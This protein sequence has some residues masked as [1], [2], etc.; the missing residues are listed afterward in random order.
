MRGVNVQE[1]VE[2]R[3]SIELPGGKI[4]RPD[5]VVQ[6]SDVGF[7]GIIETKG[8]S[9]RFGDTRSMRQ[10]EDNLRISQATGLPLYY[11]VYG[12]I[13]PWWQEQLRVNN[14]QAL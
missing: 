1:E 7:K 5:F 10:F 2:S 13:D 12:R 14:V 6:S 11:D 3:P 8:G 9:L 4:R